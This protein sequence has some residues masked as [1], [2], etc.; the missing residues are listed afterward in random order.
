M[1]QVLC[2]TNALKISH[3]KNKGCFQSIKAPI[4]RPDRRS[5]A[6]L[7]FP[8]EKRIATRELRRWVQKGSIIPFVEALATKAGPL[9]KYNSDT[10]LAREIKF[11]VLAL[12]ALYD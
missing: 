6:D 8:P 11:T 12:A 1:V 2:R 9:G 10:Y 4:F 3:D 7:S 5:I